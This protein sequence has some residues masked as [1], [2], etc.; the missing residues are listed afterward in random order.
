MCGV[1]IVEKSFRGKKPMVVFQ[2]AEH[3]STNFV[4]LTRKPTF[5]QHDSFQMRC[6]ARLCFSGAV[7]TEVDVR[8]CPKRSRRNRTTVRQLPLSASGFDPRTNTSWSVRH[9]VRPLTCLSFVSM[10]GCRWNLKMLQCASCGQWFHE[11]CTQ[12]LTKPLLYGDRWVLSMMRFCSRAK[13]QIWTHL[14]IY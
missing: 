10:L 12:C 1:K 6:R 4:W 3:F 5:Q 14:Y 7:W 8:C 13:A 11:A 2:S 9:V